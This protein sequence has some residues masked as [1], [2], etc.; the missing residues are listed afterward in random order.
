MAKL[1]GTDGI[2]GVANTF[3]MTPEMMLKI[4]LVVGSMLS[5]RAA[6]IL[7][8]RDSR[9]SGPMLEAALT[10]GIL[11]TGM[12]VL[13][14]GMIPTPAVAFLTRRLQA[15]AGVVI[16]ASHNPA[17]DNGIKFFAHD[18]FKLSDAL[19]LAIEDRV[20]AGQL[21]AE[22]PTGDAVGQ[23][24]PFADAGERYLEHL[25]TSVW[26][27]GIPDCRGLK[28]VIDCANGAAS[29]IAPAAFERLRLAP[30][31]LA[32]APDGV[33]INRQ[34]GALHTA[35]L[36]QRVVQEQADLGVAFDGDADRLMLVDERGV[37]LDGDR[38]LAILALDLLRRQQL[39]N[40]TLVVTVMSNLGL[41]IAMRDAGIE[42]VRTAV[43]DRHV[44]EKMK[45]LGANVGGEQS[46][47]IVLFEHGTT[48]DGL[49][50][51]LSILK[52]LHAAGK[53]LSALAACM[54]PFPQTLLNIPVKARKP[55]ENM[56]GVSQ[57]IRSAEQELGAR[58]RVLVRYSGTELL[59]RVMV[60]A[61]HE[62][63]VQ[64]IA[65]TIAAEIRQENQSELI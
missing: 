10:A 16:S 53:P 38:I 30:V 45:A 52:I 2:R 28:I 47:H 54:Q 29:A 25:L 34:C 35:T 36:Q 55:M 31:V 7:I 33:N 42:V 8:G 19:E 37:Q 49:A 20:F 63:A 24:R 18:G 65:E 3:P 41:E 6:G 11:A 46:G 51:A 12:D 15:G 39:S 27:D 5:T 43:G 64:R 17:Q 59:A 4:G 13:P 26:G 60:E 48:G 21:S 40:K 62:D 1:F 22:R 14:A 9:R 32:A 56:I 50:A 23:M 58:G 44:V 57:A 61:E